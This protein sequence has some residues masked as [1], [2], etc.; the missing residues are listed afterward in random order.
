MDF[1]R[2]YTKEQ[3]IEK[4]KEVHEDKYDYSKVEYIH[5]KT[6]IIISCPEHGEFSQKPNDHLNG[7]GCPECASET[8][9]FW[10]PEYLKKHHQDKLDETCTLYIIECYYDNELFIKIG[11]TTKTIEDRY[12]N[13]SVLN[14]YQ[15][16]TLYEYQSTLLECS[17][18]EQELLN[19]FKEYRYE[20]INWFSGST[21][22]LQHRILSDVLIKIQQK[23]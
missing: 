21:E 19:K 3:F 8:R 2:I 22:C 9:G 1:E 23:D 10:N 16:T 4:A 12:N 11:I 18:I 6:K 5:N 15:Y 17:E 7:H 14:G 13:E 20:P